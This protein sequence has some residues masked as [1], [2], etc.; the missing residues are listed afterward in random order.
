MFTL[1]A[2]ADD[3]DM[4]ADGPSI[5]DGSEGLRWQVTQWV[6][7]NGSRRLLALALSVVILGFL[8]VAGTLWVL[9]MERLVVETRAVQT[10]FSTLLGGV[11]LF[12]SVVLSINIAALSQ[13]FAPLQVKLAQIEDS[14]EFQSELE[15]LVDDG[16][17]PAGMRPFLGFVIR[18][19]RSET[20]ALADAANDTGRGRPGRE[21]ERGWRRAQA[22]PGDGTSGSSSVR[23]RHSWYA[24]RGA[25]RPIRSAPRSSS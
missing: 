5:P 22:R 14:I 17:S 7:L 21:R 9:E 19:I 6:L 15:A 23:S 18:A 1:L 2:R 11:I 3:E 20:R 8:L 10:L 16:V 12:V 24:S 4:G 25:S 13:E